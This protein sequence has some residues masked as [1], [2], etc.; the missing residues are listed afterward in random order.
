M[1]GILRYL[2]ERLGFFFLLFDN[3]ACTLVLDNY[4]CTLSLFFDN[5]ACTLGLFFDNCACT[6]GLFFDNCACTLGW[7]RAAQTGTGSRR[8][9][10]E[11]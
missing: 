2:C 7:S 1:L 4:A 9:R 11:R 8:L 5:C 6:L 10:S 3:Y